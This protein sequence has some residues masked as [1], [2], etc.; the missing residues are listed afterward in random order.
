[1]EGWWTGLAPYRHGVLNLR[2][3]WPKGPA[4]ERVEFV[5]GLADQHLDIPRELMQAWGLAEGTHVKVRPAP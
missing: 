2:V 5:P 3:I 4:V 1:M